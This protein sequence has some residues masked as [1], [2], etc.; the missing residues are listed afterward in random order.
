MLAETKEISG[1]V[2]GCWITSRYPWHCLFLI[3]LIRKC[4]FFIFPLRSWYSW[5]YFNSRLRELR[6]RH[7]TTTGRTTQTPLTSWTWCRAALT[8]YWRSCQSS[9]NSPS[10]S[11]SFWTKEVPC[12]STFKPASSNEAKILCLGAWIMKR[13]CNSAWTVW[14]RYPIFYLHHPHHTI[15]TTINTTS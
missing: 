14:E 11:P 7:L 10:P 4:L 13:K 1:Y 2:Y 6:S 8:V 3:L 5:I 9:T 15:E 12:L